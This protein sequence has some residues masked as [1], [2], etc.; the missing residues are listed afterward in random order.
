[1]IIARRSLSVA[2]CLAWGVLTHGAAASVLLT[3]DQALTAWPNADPTISMAG[4]FNPDYGNNNVGLAASSG[5]TIGQTFTTVDGF[6][7]G[8]IDLAYDSGAAQQIGL[9]IYQVDVTENATNFTYAPTPMTSPVMDV[10]LSLSTDTDGPRVLT[11]ELTGDDQVELAS[12]TVY[13]MEFY[14]VDATTSFAMRRRGSSFYGGGAVFQDGVS[15]NGTATRD[16]LARLYA[17]PE[18]GS[19]LL[20]GSG[21]LLMCVR[22][23]TR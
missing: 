5:A 14:R 9:T 4:G 15:V 11:I 13:V 20:I 18:P 1:M 23:S 3:E 7:L 12:D 10:T 22:R 16:A 2:T 17:V 6:T 19:L 8:K 21:G